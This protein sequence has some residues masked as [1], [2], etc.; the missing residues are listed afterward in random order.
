MIVLVVL[1]GVLTLI[2]QL[3]MKLKNALQ[4]VLPCKLLLFVLVQCIPS[5]LKFLGI[6]LECIVLENQFITGH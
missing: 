6:A 2:V 5:M 1:K 3:S 4:L